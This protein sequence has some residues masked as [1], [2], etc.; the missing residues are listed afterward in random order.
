M[1][2]NAKP[3]VGP[4]HGDAVLVVAMRN[5]TTGEPGAKGR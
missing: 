5:R 1:V 2:V 4:D 3:A